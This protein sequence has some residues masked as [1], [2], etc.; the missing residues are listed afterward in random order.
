MPRLIVSWADEV[1]IRS[2]VLAC[3]VGLE[4]RV[5]D[6]KG[7]GRRYGQA[8]ALRSVLSGSLDET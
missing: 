2:S 4:L 8:R 7:F 3:E 5:V 6:V 1:G